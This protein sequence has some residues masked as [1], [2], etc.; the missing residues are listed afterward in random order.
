MNPELSVLAFDT[1]GAASDALGVVGELGRDGFISLYDAAIV[2]KSLAGK[3]KIR[4]NQDLTSPEGSLVGAISGGL[5]GLLAGPAGALAGAVA[6]AA[7]G[8]V[9]AAVADFGF[10]KKDLQELAELLP[11][12]SSALLV[13]YKDEVP[14]MIASAISSS[15]Q[16]P[17][18]TNKS[19]PKQDISAMFTTTRD[20][21]K[22][23]WDELVAS[24]KQTI[25]KI[26]DQMQTQVTK[27]QG[28]LNGLKNKAAT[29]AANAKA[30]DE[31]EMDKLRTNLA[32]QQAALEGAY[33]AQLTSFKAYIAGLK[34]KAATAT[35]E[36]K[37]KTDAKMAEAQASYKATQEKFKSNAQA[38]LDELNARI[39]S[40]QTKAA[41]L[42][43]EAQVKANL[44]TLE[45]KT[46]QEQAQNK[47]NELKTA[48]DAAWGDVARGW[49]KARTDLSQAYQQAA[50]EFNNQ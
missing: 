17:V 19:D 31:A 24:G 48:S 47:L 41:A 2:S 43:G 34:E 39:E 5:I 4:D 42:K 7:T 38:A 11:P 26:T 36:A 6:G 8:G 22:N 21:V 27:T 10:P 13:Y 9:T 46:K 33:T 14:G 37:T 18:T 23:H 3:T 30:Q 12:D 35:G 49:S 50:R 20:N 28:E 45:L 16:A 44:M 15:L 29:A 32:N 25:E 40:L 1:E